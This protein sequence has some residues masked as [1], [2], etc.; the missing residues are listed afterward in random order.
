MQSKMMGKQ[1]QWQYSIVN[2]IVTV[3]YSSVEKPVN[4]QL[5]YKAVKQ[6]K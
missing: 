6:S 5:R 1:Y 4:L 3:T 2:G